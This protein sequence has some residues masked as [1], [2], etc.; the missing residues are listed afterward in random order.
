MA[1][2]ATRAAR[3]Y[4][5][6]GRRAIKAAS[7]SVSPHLSNGRHH[8]H[9]FLAVFVATTCQELPALHFTPALH[10]WEFPSSG[11]QLGYQRPYATDLGHV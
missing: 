10:H 3:S 7:C 4:M 9:L 6:V 8:G 5:L 2:E 1:V 11:P